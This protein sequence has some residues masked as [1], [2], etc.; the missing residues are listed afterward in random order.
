MCNMKYGDKLEDPG[1]K[2]QPQNEDQLGQIISPTTLEM[3]RPTDQSRGKRQGI[4]LWNGN[5]NDDDR[6]SNEIFLTGTK[7]QT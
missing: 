5:D 2:K 6:D 1:S 3:I 7:W 4:S